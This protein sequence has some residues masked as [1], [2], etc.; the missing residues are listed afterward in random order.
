[1]YALQRNYSDTENCGIAGLLGTLLLWMATSVLVLIM[2]SRNHRIPRFRAR[3]IDRDSTLEEG[4]VATRR[5]ARFAPVLATTSR[6]VHCGWRGEYQKALARIVIKHRNAVVV[7][8][9]VLMD[10]I[11]PFRT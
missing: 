3:D 2:G 8:V 5:H 10:R 4:N 1:M 7:Y 9:N 11:P 6:N